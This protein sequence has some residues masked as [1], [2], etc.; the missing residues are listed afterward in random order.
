MPRVKPCLEVSPKEATIIF[1]SIKAN[2][3]SDEDWAQVA[4]D[5]YV[6]ATAEFVTWD[7]DEAWEDY[8]IALNWNEYW[9]RA[10]GWAEAQLSENEYRKRVKEYEKTE[11]E[12]R[13]KNY[14][15][16]VDWQTLPERAHELLITADVNWNSPERMSRDM[17]L[18]NLLRTSE[19]MCYEFIWQP[20]ARSKSAYP[21]FQ[22]YEDRVAQR[23]IGSYPRVWDYVH[24]CEDRFFLGF[25]TS[26][27]LG[28]DEGK[29]MVERLPKALDQ[30]MS[31]RNDEH[32]PLG[33][34]SLESVGVYYK[35]FLGIGMEG[36]LPR[37]AHIGRKLRG[38]RRGGR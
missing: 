22:R 2:S 15:F 5:C 34:L 20:L 11:A 31:I 10:R 33:T 23:P 7:E 38:G 3:Q 9:Q 35:K 17:I 37:L 16:G 4:A 36:V 13:L 27:G 18:T 32:I 28:Q 1:E 8:G 14:F 21:E 29:F 24:V 30:L 19:A 12:R 26:R 6:L 25:C